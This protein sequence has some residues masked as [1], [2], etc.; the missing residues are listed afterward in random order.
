MINIYDVQIKRFT[1][2]Y[3][4]LA[5]SALKCMSLN[6]IAVCVGGIA[7]G[8][9]IDKGVQWQKEGQAMRAQRMDV[10]SLFKRST[11]IVTQ[12]EY[13]R[14]AVA[15]SV[16]DHFAVASDFAFYVAGGINNRRR[17]IDRIETFRRRPD[18]FW[19]DGIEN[20]PVHLAY[21]W[22]QW[23]PMRKKE[24]CQRIWCDWKTSGPPMHSHRCGTPKAEYSFSTKV[25]GE[26][27][28]CDSE[29][30]ENY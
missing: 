20:E 25:N 29:F 14:D 1:H 30:V 27:H 28:Y 13:L 22:P 5:R 26:A 7:D 12:Y 17:S 23:R 21:E 16:Q 6:Y 19:F 8:G 15:T 10:I 18:S 4:S 2:G 9:T 3:L 11:D 24:T